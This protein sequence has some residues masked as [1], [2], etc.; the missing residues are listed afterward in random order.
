MEPGSPNAILK[1]KTRNPTETGWSTSIKMKQLQ[2]D[3]EHD[4]FNSD[5]ERPDTPIAWKV[6]FGRPFATKMKDLPNKVYRIDYK[7]FCRLPFPQSIFELPS[8]AVDLLSY[9]C[10]IDLQ[11]FAK[12][13]E[14]ITQQRDDY[15]FR[16]IDNLLFL[17][18]KLGKK[19]I[20]KA[21]R[22]FLKLSV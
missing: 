2:T 5:E 7:Q 18:D 14:I 9:I 20:E 13:K 11:I 19:K 10:R 1:L 12:K 21:Y 4:A 16:S 22:V 17:K 6:A 15:F 3:K 8:V